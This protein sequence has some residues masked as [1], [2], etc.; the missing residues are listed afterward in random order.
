MDAKPVRT[1]TDAAGVGWLVLS[2]GG[3]VRLPAATAVGGGGL[4]QA[5]ADGLYVNVGGDTMSGAL[6]ITGGGLEVA[7]GVAV[8]G[9]GIAVNGTTRSYFEAAIEAPGGVWLENAPTDP[10]HAASKGYVDS[11]DAAVQVYADTAIGGHNAQGTAH[12]QLRGTATPGTLGA[13]AVVGTSTRFAR[14]DHR[15]P[16]PLASDIGAPAGGISQRM[17]RSSSV[18]LSANVMTTVTGWATD[19]A[20]PAP[21]GWTGSQ[22]VSSTTGITLPAGLW[23]I[24]ISVTIGGLAASTDGVVTIDPRLDGSKPAWLPSHKYYLNS[25]A[26]SSVRPDQGDLTIIVPNSTAG[27]K[28]NIAVRCSVAATLTSCAIAVVG[29]INQTY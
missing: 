24:M 6:R 14:E 5:T 1:Y 4:D 26:S 29:P 17:T 25:N 9:G 18:A 13:V 19:A 12:S 23:V 3:R 11:G 10:V 27:T 28:L 15:H 21:T 2:N 7:D 22:A 20:L 8:D 16:L